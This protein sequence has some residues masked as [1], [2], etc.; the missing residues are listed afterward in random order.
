[1][2]VLNH[3]RY[4]GI[5]NSF[6]E[7]SLPITTVLPT[8]PLSRACDKHL[9]ISKTSPSAPLP[10]VPAG[11]RGKW[12]QQDTSLSISPLTCLT[13]S[14]C[15]P[16][17]VFSFLKPDGLSEQS[18]QA[19]VSH[20][21][22]DRVHNTFLGQ[23]GPDGL[24]SPPPSLCITNTLAHPAKSPSHRQLLSSRET[25]LSS[26]CKCQLTCHPRASAFLYFSHN[27]RLSAMF[28]LSVYRQSSEY[29]F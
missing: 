7:T 19:A 3:F 24:A 10:S 20:P 9:G 23:Q 11:K 25:F 15:L 29:P 18:Y 28:Q 14:S 27:K 22:E 2:A 8:V 12:Q 1:M 17:S 5:L 4:I 21:S 6:S 13:A 26:P 16:C